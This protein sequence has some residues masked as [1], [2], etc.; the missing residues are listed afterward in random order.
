LLG[1]KAETFQNPVLYWRPPWMECLKCGGKFCFYN[2]IKAFLA[3]ARWHF[4]F[5]CRRAKSLNKTLTW[6]MNDGEKKFCI[7]FFFSNYGFK[8]TWF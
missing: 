6:I 1:R 5:F 3:S 8:T 7:F 2:P 4:D